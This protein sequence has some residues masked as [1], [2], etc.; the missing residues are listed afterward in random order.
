[1]TLISSSNQKSH[2]KYLNAV[3]LTV[4]NYKFSKILIF[5]CKLE[6]YYRQQVLANIFL[7][8]SLSSLRNCLPNTQ[9]T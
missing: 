6:F 2:I 9:S 7:E 8:M 5:P 3:K 4:V 1:M